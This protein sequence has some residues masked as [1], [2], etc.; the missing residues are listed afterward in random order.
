MIIS[1]NI[2]PIK[3]SF[4][5]HYCNF[6]RCTLYRILLFAVT[7]LFRSYFAKINLWSQLREESPENPPRFHIN[8]VNWSHIKSIKSASERSSK[9]TLKTWPARC[10]EIIISYRFLVLKYAIWQLNPSGTGKLDEPFW[11]QACC[12]DAWML[13]VRLHSGD[14]HLFQLRGKQ[15]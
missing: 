2:L 8:P 4:R 15:R 12:L 6:L 5:C 7:H 9:V 14:L 13:G 3:N 1:T 10:L 11:A